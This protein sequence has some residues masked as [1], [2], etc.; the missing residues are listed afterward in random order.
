MPRFPEIRGYLPPPLYERESP[1]E[2]EGEEKIRNYLLSKKINF[3]MNRPLSFR[4]RRGEFQLRPDFQLRDRVIIEW[5]SQGDKED[6]K[7]KKE[8]F[9]RYKGSVIGQA[10][11]IKPYFLL[12]KK[13]IYKEC[14][15]TGWK[16]HFIDQKELKKDPNQ[17][18]SIEQELD[19]ILKS[20]K[21]PKS[22]EG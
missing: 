21:I 17:P 1:D 2:K 11:N 8:E 16:V 22:K 20:R 12:D 14:E 7:F 18:I 15:E 5:W 6:S 9:E 19:K 3:K 10:K 4:A 13:D